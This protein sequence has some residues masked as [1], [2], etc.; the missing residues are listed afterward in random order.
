MR[1]NRIRSPLKLDQDLIDFVPIS[2]LQR[3]SDPSSSMWYSPRTLRTSIHNSTKDTSVDA[4]QHP[5]C[6]PISAPHFLYQIFNTQTVASSSHFVRE[7]PRP[8][9]PPGSSRAALPA[10]AGR[11]S[12]PP[13]FFSVFPKRENVRLHLQKHRS[14]L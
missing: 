5:K 12:R 6:V 13:P 2:E 3:G 11:A 7:E 14:S 8:S 9:S 1:G 10:E 4:F